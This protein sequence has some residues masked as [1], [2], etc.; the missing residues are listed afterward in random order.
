MV[1]SLKQ[2]FCDLP[3]S[4]LLEV[5]EVAAMLEVLPN[6]VASWCRTGELYSLK[7]AYADKHGYYYSIKVESVTYF[8]MFHSKK[9]AHAKRRM[10]IAILQGTQLSLAEDTEDTIIVPTFKAL[11]VL[12]K[13]QTPQNH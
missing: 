7:M 2:N 6:D 10:R 5:C 1:M 9:L 12:A 13:P 4:S 3:S 8:T 11:A